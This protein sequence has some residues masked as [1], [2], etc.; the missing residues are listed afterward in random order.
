MNYRGQHIVLIV[1]C[2]NEEAAI[3]AVVTGFGPAMPE[4]EIFVFDNNSS[5]RTIEVARKA[6]AKVVS[7]PLR[8]KGNVVRRMFADVDADLYVM[9]DGDA[10]SERV[11]CTPVGGQT[12]G[13][14]S[15]YGGWLSAS[16]S[17]GC[18]RGLSAGASMG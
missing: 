6:G 16:R 10:T 1:P 8:G 7:V 4:L 11:R 17:I 14:S 9:V 2:Y 15:G 12:V 5:D 3:G 13:R 18:G